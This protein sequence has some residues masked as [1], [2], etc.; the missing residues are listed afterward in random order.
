MRYSSYSFLTSALDGVSGQ[1][2][3]PAVLCPGERTP[4]T[5]CTGGWVGLRAGLDT[6]VRGKIL[7]PCRGSNLNRP[8]VQSIARHYTDW[9]TPALHCIL[10]RNIIP[11]PNTKIIYSHKE[12]SQYHPKTTKLWA[13]NSWSV[14]QSH[15]I[16]S[17]SPLPCS[18]KPVTGQYS[19]DESNPHSCAMFP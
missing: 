15:F 9:A 11:M 3:A 1:R 5:H 18:Q 2:H 8:V 13:A 6:E 10:Y 7:C 19:E 16:T 12:S 4:G 17:G 14:S